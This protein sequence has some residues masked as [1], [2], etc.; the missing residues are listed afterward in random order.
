L[1]KTILSR[2]KKQETTEQSLFVIKKLLH[3]KL[4]FK[5]S[6]G[7]GYDNGLN[8]RGKNKG[9]QARVCPEN[10][11]AFF[12]PCGCHSLNLVVGDSAVSCTEAVSF[13]GIIQRILILF[14]ASVGI[15]KDN[16][17]T[18]T[19]KPLC[20]TRWECRIDCLKPLRYQ[21]AEIEF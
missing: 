8:M 14:S 6:R 11:R 19:V 16:V 10:P 20:N 12:M 3:S 18:V 17:P 1:F 9:V 13:F 2:F 21:I 7:Q 5:N 15:L 4:D